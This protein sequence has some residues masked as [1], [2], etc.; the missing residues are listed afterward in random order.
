M[1]LTAGFPDAP[2]ADNVSSPF[3]SAARRLF[4]PPLPTVRLDEATPAFEPAAYTAY[5]GDMR[6]M[7]D[8]QLAAHFLANGR[9][10]RRVYRRLRLILR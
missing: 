10:E 1:C 7:T 4:G 3:P 6:N 8:Q 9:K 5:Y 2:R